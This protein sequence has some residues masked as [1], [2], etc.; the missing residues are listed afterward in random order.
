LGLWA[1]L[2]GENG[3]KRCASSLRSPSTLF[4]GDGEEAAA[5]AL[6]AAE[7]VG[8]M[9]FLEPEARAGLG[10]VLAAAAASRCWSFSFSPKD[11]RRG[12]AWQ[13]QT[14][15]PLEMEAV[16]CGQSADRRERGGLRAVLT[17]IYRESAEGKVR[18]NPNLAEG[19]SNR[20]I[21]N[22]GWKQGGR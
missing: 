7:M 8:D 14:A 5:T 15:P 17:K 4:L 1:R 21:S 13:P 20:R 22:H 2:A 10:V 16:L 18:R 6:D 11:R 9:K 19:E 12:E 3:A